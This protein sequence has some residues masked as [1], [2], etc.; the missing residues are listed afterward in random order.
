M[1]KKAKMNPFAKAMSKERKETKKQEKSEKYTNSK[2]SKMDMKA[3]KA[4]SKKKGC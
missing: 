2:A 4:M 1:A 3:D